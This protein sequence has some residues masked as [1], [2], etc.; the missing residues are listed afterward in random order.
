MLGLGLKNGVFQF[1][2][3]GVSAQCAAWYRADLGITLNGSNVSAWADQSGSNNNLVQAT[4]AHQPPYT[5]SSAHFNS[6]PIITFGGGS[7]NWLDATPF[8]LGAG[9]HCF[10]YLVHRILANAN[11]V[12]ATYGLVAGGLTYENAGGTTL[13]V[14]SQSLLKAWGSTTLNSSVAAYVYFTSAGAS[15]VV[16]VNV[17]GGTE[18]TSTGTASAIADAQKLEVGAYNATFGA[19]FELAEMV[20]Y[21]SKPSAADLAALYTYFRNLYGAV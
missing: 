17:S 6:K 3:L 21:K 18:L 19:N 11:S 9:G 5:S 2:P 8:A 13:E 7:T 12:L 14:L 10:F 15:S 4:G 16:G 20:I 1:T